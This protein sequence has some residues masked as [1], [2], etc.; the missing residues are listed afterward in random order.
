MPVKQTM[1]ATTTAAW[2]ALAYGSDEAEKALLLPS[3]L[4]TSLYSNVLRFGPAG[5][6]V[7]ECVD[8]LTLKTETQGSPFM[9]ATLNVLRAAT[10]DGR[11]IK[12]Y[13]AHKVLSKANF[14]PADEILFKDWVRAAGYS[15]L[16]IELRETAREAMRPYDGIHGATMLLWLLNGQYLF[17]KGMIAEDS[18]CIQAGNAILTDLGMPELKWNLV[19]ESGLMLNSQDW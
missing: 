1:D 3:E 8:A 6:Q 12:R 4:R 5:D 17:P 9:L 10:S 13:Y 14:D 18:D 2:L 16:G 11:L 15:L 19:E 7:K